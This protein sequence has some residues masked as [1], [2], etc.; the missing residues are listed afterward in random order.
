M[1]SGSRGSSSRQMLNWAGDQNVDFSIVDGVASTIVASLSL[2]VSGMG[3]TH[4][5]IGGYTTQTPVLTRS[6]ELLLRSAEYAVF[7]PVM[8][9]HLGNEP[10]ANVQIYDSPEL[11]SKFARLTKIH[12][13]LFNYTK[14]LLD[15][16]LNEGIPV[17]RPVFLHYPNNAEGKDLKTQYMFGS[18]VIVAPV[19][20]KGQ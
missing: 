17:L 15:L 18:D 11:L 20:H 10:N 4:F 12:S 13:R 2:S 8:R 19:I 9:T 14:S 6:E 1:R 16:N 3:V 5:D 7:T